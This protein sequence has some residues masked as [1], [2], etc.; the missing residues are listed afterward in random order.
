MSNYGEQAMEILDELH[1]ERLD[2]G[3][4]YVPLADAATLLMEY[5]SLGVSLERLKELVEADREGRLTVLPCKRG[6]KV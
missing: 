4:E 3:S 5:E 1:T 2:Y 6:D